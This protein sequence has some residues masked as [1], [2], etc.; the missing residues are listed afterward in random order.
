MKL[1]LC[2]PRTLSNGGLTLNS[3][4][5]V[6]PPSHGFASP[7]CPESP[8]VCF[9]SPG[10]ACGQKEAMKEEHHLKHIISNSYNITIYIYIYCK[11]HKTIIRPSYPHF[12]GC[13]FCWLIFLSSLDDLSRIALGTGLEIHHSGASKARWKR[14]KWLFHGAFMVGLIWEAWEHIGKI[15]GITF[16]FFISGI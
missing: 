12:L 14:W 15:I 3:N 11:H 5:S 7:K 9:Q 8:D 4:S 16:F 10:L 6:H 13:P 1:E 2:S